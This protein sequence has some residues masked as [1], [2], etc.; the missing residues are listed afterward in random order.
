[1]VIPKIHGH[2]TERGV[3]KGGRNSKRRERG[4]GQGEKRER[5]E[6]AYSA[7]SGLD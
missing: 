3:G 6:H 4:M 2:M 1:M 5:T 7:N